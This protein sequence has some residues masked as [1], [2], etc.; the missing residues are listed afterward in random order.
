M[1][2]PQDPLAPP[3][4]PTEDRRA[5]RRAPLDRPVLVE[6]GSRSL[7]ARAVDVSGGGIALRTDQ[8][9]GPAERVS[10]YFELPIGYAVET[11]AEVVRADG[12]LVALRF[13]DTPREAIVAVRSF[14]R[15][16]GSLRID[17][18]PPSSRMTPAPASPRP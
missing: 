9:L 18:P 12:N 16:S 5:H 8:A 1:A 7:T 3:S 2:G 4:A 15:I 17:G 14:C 10:V 11:S 13:V 6:L